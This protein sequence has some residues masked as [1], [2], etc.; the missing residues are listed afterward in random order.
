MKK[1]LIA[2]RSI[3]ILLFFTP[4]FFSKCGQTFYRYNE[5]YENVEEWTKEQNTGYIDNRPILDKIIAPTPSEY[6]GLGISLSCVMSLW[7][8]PLIFI[9]SVTTIILVKR[10]KKMKKEISDADFVIYMIS[11]IF[12]SAMADMELLIAYL[13]LITGFI[14]L[15]RRK[16]ES[17]Q[18]HFSAAF[19]LF[20][21]ISIFIFQTGADEFNTRREITLNPE[22]DHLL[23]GFYLTFGWAFIDLLLTG[24]VCKTGKQSL[25]S[26][27]SILEIHNY[28]L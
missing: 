16:N 4:F 11:V 2:N 1:L 9:M 10:K 6:S 22:R 28:Q 18:F 5:D 21:L 15:I 13:T 23:W 12:I 26:Q 24:L 17:L 27:E 8:F 7:F 3:L 19:A 14:L 25:T 20:M